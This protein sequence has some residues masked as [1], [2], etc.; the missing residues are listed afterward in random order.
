MST[1]RITTDLKN[2]KDDTVEINGV[3]I[4]GLTGFNVEFDAKEGVPQVVLYTRPKYL[5]IILENMPDEII[6]DTSSPNDFSSVMAWAAWDPKRQVWCDT[7]SGEPL[8]NGP[9]PLLFPKD[10]VGDDVALQA[11]AESRVDRQP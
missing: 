7:K 1:V 9:L 6:V 3:K 5:E 11:K 8:P 4:P 10:T 2:V